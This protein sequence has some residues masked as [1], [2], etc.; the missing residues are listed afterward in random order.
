MGITDDKLKAALA[1]LA[2][3]GELDGVN[4]ELYAVVASVPFAG[5]AISS[6]LT[7]A[8]KRRV[9]E[10]AE[11]VFQAVKERL[12]NVEKTKIDEEYFKSDE[13]MTVVLLAIEQLQTTHYKK[14]LEMLANAIANSGR[15]DFSSESRKELFMRIMRDLSPQHVS[16]L[17]TMGGLGPI[18]GEQTNPTGEHLTVLQSLAAHGLVEESYEK[19]KSSTYRPFSNDLAAVIAEAIA[20]PS[21]HRFWLSDFGAK[22][23]EFFNRSDIS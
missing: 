10:R 3:E 13:F 1:N 17:A 6:L 8:A 5:N 19:Q 7:G 2:K 14:K 23:L 11:E 9:V 12:E 16:T 21:T 22:F 20:A 4:E 18:L 15:V